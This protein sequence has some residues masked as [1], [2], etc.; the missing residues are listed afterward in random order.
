MGKI[1]VFV[2]A[3]P[4]RLEGVLKGIVTRR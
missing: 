2:L 4:G 1:F 3:L